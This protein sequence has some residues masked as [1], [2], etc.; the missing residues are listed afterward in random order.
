VTQ[1]KRQSTPKGVFGG[2][3]IVARIIFVGCVLVLAAYAGAF[4]FAQVT[5]GNNFSA[6]LAVNPNEP[7]ALAKKAEAIL[8]RGGSTPARLNI[9]KRTAAVSL[10][11]Q[12]LNPIA[13]RSFVVAQGLQKDQEWK[14]RAGMLLMK[15]SKRDIGTHLWL[16]EESVARN[17]IPRILFHYDM[18]M[19]TSE[20][21]KVLLYPPLVGAIADPLIRKAF[22]PYIKKR[23][24]WLNGFLDIAIQ[25]SA[26]P[27]IIASLI[28]EAGGMRD[29]PISLTLANQLLTRLVSNGQLH[30]AKSFYS[31]LEARDVADLKS[32][33]LNWA[34]LP[35]RYPAMGW[36]EQGTT[37]AG[38]E[39]ASPDERQPS[40]RA[41][42][43]SGHRQ[44]VVRKI[45]YFEPGRYS[46][47]VRYGEAELTSDASTRWHLR[48]IRGREQPVVWSS[49]E[50]HPRSGTA[51]QLALD[52]P[53]R[54][55]AQYLELELAGGESQAGAQLQINSVRILNN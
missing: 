48:C 9:A 51:I 45:L 35:G 53:A 13:L 18:A 40:I 12:A 7:I 28:T 31:T 4:S 43:E 47:V 34:S 33:E 14:Q 27:S 2:A 5:R 23:P 11:A 16:I 52:I 46:L 44:I 30:E 39:F 32:P 50:L 8:V 37:S 54:C 3:A 49:D 6:S 19:R 10:H 22:A 25:T 38:V 26:D 17:D 29:D 36:L 20:S 55:E 41:F 1:T 24:E 15:V 42:A 21:S